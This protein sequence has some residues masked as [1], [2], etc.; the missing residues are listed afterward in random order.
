MVDL[1]HRSLGDGPP[2]LL[3]HGL[4]GAADNLGALA[5][6]LSDSYRVI[7][8]DLRN[9]GRS[10]H[11]AGHSYPLM[12]ADV[13]AVLDR[14]GVDRVAIFGHSMGGKVAMQMALTA[15]E[16]VSCLIVGDIAPIPYGHHHENVFRAMTAAE[17]V[18]GDRR[19]A[20]AAMDPYIEDSRVTD[21]LLTNWRRLDGGAWG[22]RL[23]LAALIDNY[24]K[25]AAAPEGE[26]YGGPTL[27]LRGALSDYITEDARDATMR[28]FPEAQLKTLAETGHWF[29]SEKP[30]MTERLVRRFLEEAA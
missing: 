3:I 14:L 6:G 1:Y 13:V 10:P 22:W 12:A 19:A 16:R 7:S 18:D 26:P 4:F 8:V 23:N 20:R 15:P 17:G 25:I 30:D 5:R 29:H 27:F 24:D 2:V 28:L 9:H 21:F 11:S